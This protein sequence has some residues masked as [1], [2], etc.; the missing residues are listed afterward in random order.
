MIK[1]SIENIDEYLYTLTDN[2]NKRYVLNIEFYEFIPKV[3]DIIYISEK[4]LN[5]NDM[6]SYGPTGSNYSKEDEED[7][8][9]IVR[10]K[11]TIYLQRYYG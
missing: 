6:Y 8:I 4:N 7:I 9:K 10:G 2:N 3:G 11:N 1:L 5:K